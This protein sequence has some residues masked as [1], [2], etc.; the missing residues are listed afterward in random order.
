M[1]K[2][3]V[4]LRL[5]TVPGKSGTVFYQVS[6]RKEVKQITTRIHLLPEEWDTSGGRV[7]LGNIAVAP[8]LSAVQRLI[9]HDTDLLKQIIRSLEMSGKSF[10]IQS[11]IDRY[12]FSR[13]AIY[14]LTYMEEHISALTSKG[15]RGTAKNW[16]CTL[17]SLSEYLGGEDIPFSELD[18]PLLLDYEEWLKCRGVKRNSSSFYMRNLRSIYNKAVRQGCVRQ[19]DPFRNIY[20]GID[21]TSKRAVDESVIAEL[22]VLELSDT[23]WLALA[24]DLFIFS[25]CTRGMSFIDMAY[26]RRTNIVN[27]IIRYTRKK[28]GQSLVV[29]IEP[30]VQEIITRYRDTVHADYILPVIRSD[31][32]KDAYRQYQTCLRYYNK[33]LKK[34]SGILGGGVSLTSYVSR[35]SWASTAYKHNVP[36]AVISDSMGH[37][38]EKTTQIYL[39]SMNEDV[40]NRANAKIV[41]S[42]DNKKIE[43]MGKKEVPKKDFF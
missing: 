19:T 7:S 12:M 8:R 1:A 39:A 14:V 32:E 42:L 41:A 34:L 13:G 36:L 2:I 23:G 9:D 38:S 11:I 15:K 16:R 37:N 10:G 40:I 24:R 6:H 43:K 35:H 4:K 3:K 22:K 27:G 33:Q 30:S 5:S 31:N 29:R 18:E 28:T 25:Y 20:T 17:N 21:K 26:L